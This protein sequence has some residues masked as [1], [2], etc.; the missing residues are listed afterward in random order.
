MEIN[1]IL[2]QKL[3]AKLLSLSNFLF[4]PDLYLMLL[5]VLPAI[6]V[7]VIV[8]LLNVKQK[9]VKPKICG[10]VQDYSRQGAENA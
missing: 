7:R 6:S 2:H 5:K 3:N 9:P 8:H 10:D 4:A 1:H